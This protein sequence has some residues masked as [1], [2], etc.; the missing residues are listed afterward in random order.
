MIDNSFVFYLHNNMIKYTELLKIF[1][2]KQIANIDL[3]TVSDNNLAIDF[4]FNYILSNNIADNIFIFGDNFEWLIDIDKIKFIF[5]DITKI[6]Y[7][8]ILFDYNLA[9]GHITKQYVNNLFYIEN[10]NTYFGYVVK[11]QYILK[12]Y[13]VFKECMWNIKSISTMWNILPKT[14]NIFCYIPKIIKSDTRDNFLIVIKS[15]KET[16]NNY[17]N[18]I[19]IINIKDDHQIIKYIYEKYNNLDF[20]CIINNLDINKIKINDMYVIIEYICKSNVD[21]I[22]DPKFPFIYFT[23]NV[24]VNAINVFVDMELM[25]NKSIDDIHIYLINLEKRK[26]RLEHAIQEFDKINLKFEKFNAIENE[27]GALGCTKSHI[28]CLK[29]AK[30]KQ[31]MYCM[32]CEDDITFDVNYDELLIYIDNFINDSKLNIISL[33]GTVQNKDTI[34]NYNDY[35]NISNDIQTT[36]CY[37]VKYNYYDKLI[38][39]FEQSECKLIETYDTKQYAIDI[40]WKQLQCVDLWITPNKTLGKQY[41]NYSDIENKY[42]DKTMIYSDIKYCIIL[43]IGGLGNRM[44]QI[45]SAYGI[46]K[47]QKKELLYIFQESN[48]HSSNTYETSIFKKLTRCTSLVENS[49]KLYEKDFLFPFIFNDNIPN[50][51]HHHLLLNGFFQNE[52]YFIDFRNDI[53][54]L[55]NI[56]FERLTYLTNKYKYLDNSFFIHIRRGDYL[57]KNKLNLDKYYEKCIKIIQEKYNNCLFYIF[58]DDIEYCKYCD[59]FKS[60]NNIYYIENE[61]EVNSLY[62]M[63]LCYLGGICANSTFSW[64]GAYLNKNNDKFI[65]FP[66]KW[67]NDNSEYDIGFEGANLISVD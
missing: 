44:F 65:L 60:I 11:K 23:N 17:F 63:S 64:W 37:I 31:Y 8:V 1:N 66:N 32:I 6:N 12:L 40:M 5:T 15:E 13:N 42:V 43:L 36:T 53:L 67:F 41:A 52:K 7:D 45:A 62:L 57:I 46:A 35:F 39:I 26:D 10:S 9:Y 4:L 48:P 21:R 18:Y 24:Y 25:Y 29:D 50:Y 51:E 19:N 27:C 54:D 28:A 56:E 58:S 2:E 20:I 49:F 22:I 33:I 34:K 61:D 16:V 14:D 38:N 3:K 47:K 30:N 59:L 55:F